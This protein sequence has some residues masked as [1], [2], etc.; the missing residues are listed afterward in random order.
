[1]KK[2]SYEEDRLLKKYSYSD[3]SYDSDYGYDSD[4]SY[5]SDYGYDSDDSYHRDV[6]RRL[7]LLLRLIFAYNK[8]VF[9]LLMLICG[10]IL[11]FGYE[12]GETYYDL[13][14]RPFLLIF[15][16]YAVACLLL[17]ISGLI[18]LFHET[19]YD[20]V[21]FNLIVVL[22]FFMVIL[23]GGFTIFCKY[24]Y[25]RMCNAE[26]KRRIEGERL[27]A[28]AIEAQKHSTY[29]LAMG[30]ISEGNYR[31][32]QRLLFDLEGYS[33]AE[34][35]LEQ[36]G[37]IYYEEAYS[38]YQMGQYAECD[39]VI[40]CID[41]EREWCNYG[42]AIELSYLNKYDHALSLY[43]EGD[44]ET[45]QAIF[46]EINNYSDS[47]NYLEMLG[48]EFYAVAVELY[49]QGEYVLCGEYLL[50]INEE[51]EWSEYTKAAELYSSASDIYKESIKEEAENIC[52]EKGEGSMRNYLV[53]KECSLLLNGEVDELVQE[54]KKER[55]S[56]TEMQTS[57]LYIDKWGRSN[58]LVIYNESIND[59]CGNSYESALVSNGVSNS[60]VSG[61]K[62]FLN[63]KY[64]YFTAT[65]SIQEY[66]RYTN[67][68]TGYIRIYG[69]EELLWSDDN[70][71]YRMS[72]YDIE[73]NVKDVNCVYIEMSGFRDAAWSH[74]LLPMLANPIVSQ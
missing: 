30:Y 37:D 38:M 23:G 61:A 18:K 35:Y 26:E 67:Y 63:K 68:L 22:Y 19:D 70:I 66:E 62:Y 53:S 31:E 47:V 52:R 42:K 46:L 4:D 33:D 5:D 2:V 14:Q 25:I 12:I 24:D 41:E 9:M 55:I 11:Y 50:F 45:A 17:T 51:N 56:L 59:S 29:E 15:W 36:I 10:F 48:E 13:N 73:I 7:P 69:D 3:G 57:G 27:Q 32:A 16:S 40:L 65:V 49:N 28:E 54:W 20:I 6:K 1:M 34:S 8:I 43:N 39:N 72:S 74:A 60:G 71:T 44:Y 64:D 58:G 21:D